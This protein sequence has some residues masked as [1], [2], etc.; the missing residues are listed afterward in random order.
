[1]FQTFSSYMFNFQIWRVPLNM[2]SVISPF[3]NRQIEVLLS[4]GELLKPLL[5]RTRS[6]G[7]CWAAIQLSHRPAPSGHAVHGEVDGLDIG[8]QHSRRFVLLRHTHRPQRRSYPICTSRSGPAPVR[9]RLSRIQALLGRVIPA[10][11]V[12][13]SGMK[14][15]S[16]VG[17]SVHY[18]LHW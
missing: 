1:M 4:L 9:R 13:V 15:R 2:L 5:D 16:L 7:R 12:P 8:G 11:W 6:R 17:L 14:M 3:V 18:A 10:G